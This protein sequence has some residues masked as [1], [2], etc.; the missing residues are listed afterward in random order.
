MIAGNSHRKRG[1]KKFYEKWTEQEGWTAVLFTRQ[2]P[3][4]FSRLS[5]PDRPQT[6]PN[7]KRSSHEAEQSRHTSE[8]GMRRGVGCAVHIK[9][10]SFEKR[11]VQ[12]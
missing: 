2:L 8:Y 11:Y 4:S 7:A 12:Q 6:T 9:Y 5:C 1:P 10:L 3:L